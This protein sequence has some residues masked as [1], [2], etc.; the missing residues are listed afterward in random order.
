MQRADASKSLILYA[1]I[2]DIFTEVYNKWISYREKL[3]PII[4]KMLLSEK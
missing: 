2:E 4:S 1:D 3:K